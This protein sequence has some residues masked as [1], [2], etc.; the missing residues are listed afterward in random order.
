LEKE[1]IKNV[2][3]SLSK[4]PTVEK[5]EI[6]EKI[7]KAKDFSDVS[8]MAQP[9]I[10][11]YLKNQKSMVEEYQYLTWFLVEYF[12]FTFRVLHNL[13]QQLS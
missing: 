9:Y 10:G 13:Q 3:K 7:K 5:L 4:V 6:I 12:R 2:K 11:K 8:K 1:I